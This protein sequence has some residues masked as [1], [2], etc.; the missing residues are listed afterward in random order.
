MW[1]GRSYAVFWQGGILRDRLAGY[2][3]GGEL[4]AETRRWSILLVPIFAST[5]ANTKLLLDC[6][7]AV[8]HIDDCRR[9]TFDSSSSSPAIGPTRHHDGQQCSPH[10][11]LVWEGRG[12][13]NLVSAALGSSSVELAK[14]AALLGDP[15]EAARLAAAGGHTCTP[16]PHGTNGRRRHARVG[17]SH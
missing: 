15:D 14:I 3:S 13:S 12:P 7:Q 11:R 4:L 17:K 2:L 16:G 5:G 6:S 8:H 9:A 10:R 1:L